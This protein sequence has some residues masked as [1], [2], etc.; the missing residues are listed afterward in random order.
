MSVW[1]TATS[2][3]RTHLVLTEQ[4]FLALRNER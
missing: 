4:R 2:D 1:P 3:E